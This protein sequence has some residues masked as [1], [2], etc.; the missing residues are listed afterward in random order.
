MVAN[1]LLLSSISVFRCIDCGLWC[2]TFSGLRYDMCCDFSWWFDYICIEATAK[3]RSSRTTDS[4][5]DSG[6]LFWGTTRATIR[7]SWSFDRTIFRI[8]GLCTVS[9][10]WCCNSFDACCLIFLST[11]SE[12]FWFIRP[13]SDCQQLKRW[14]TRIS[15][16]QYLVNLSQLLLA[17]VQLAHHP[18][19]PPVR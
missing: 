9:E 10:F 19:I 8:L 5:R 4:V 3:G 12:K 15:H 7:R 11:F 2:N 16:L 14:P 1:S 13:K 6:C 18:M 17:P